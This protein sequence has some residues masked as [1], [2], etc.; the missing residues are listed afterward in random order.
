MI[1]S[2]ANGDSKWLDASVLLQENMISWP[3]NPRFRLNRVMDMETGESHTVSEITLS[4]HSGTHIDAPLHFIRDGKGVDEMPMDIS[5]CRANVIPIRDAELITVNELEDFHLDPGQSIL[6]KTRNSPEAWQK[7]EFTD[8]FVA[9]SKEAAAY[10]VMKKPKLVGI[11]YLSVGNPKYDGEEVHRILLQGG[12]WI[13]EG[14]NL[15]DIEPGI[16]TMVCL[17]LKIKGGDGAPAR[18][19]LMP[20]K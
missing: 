14:L 9:I 2:L 13:I 17:P 6:F 11:D 19:I 7:E 1:N 10:L 3:G 16:Y 4:S 12:I 8:D 15:T 5:V 18:V 20:E